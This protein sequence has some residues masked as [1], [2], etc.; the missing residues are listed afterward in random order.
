MKASAD[1]YIERA[2]GQC[3]IIIIM[4]VTPPPSIGAQDAVLFKR[5]SGCRGL[6]RRMP[7]VEQTRFGCHELK[8]K[9]M[10]Y[11]IYKICLNSSKHLLTYTVFN[12]NSLP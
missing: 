2:D 6:V 11:K 10:F 5:Y 7:F 1:M 8:S 3:V 9:N 12:R 4:R